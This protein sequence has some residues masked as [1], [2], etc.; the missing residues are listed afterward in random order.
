MEDR[1]AVRRVLRGEK[2]AFGHIVEAHY[3]RCLRYATRMLGSREDAEDV[4]QESFVRAYRALGNYDERGQFQAWL[5]QILV[6]RCRSRAGQKDRKANWVPVEEAIDLPARVKEED[7]LQN[8]RVAQALQQLPVEDREALVLKYVEDL[9]Y[10]EMSK[11][12]GSGVSALKMRVKRAR[13]RL[14]KFLRETSFV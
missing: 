5:F 4:V 11:Q 12:T 14:Q 13:D 3:P 1:E 8:R 2:Q 9:S 7:A 6:N 10:P